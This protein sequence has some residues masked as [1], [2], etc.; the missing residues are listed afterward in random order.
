MELP[1][2]LYDEISNFCKVNSIEN[3]NDFILKLTKQGFTIE[4]YGAT[5][6]ERVVEKTV[7]IVKEVPVEK[8]VEVIKEVPIEKLTIDE[9]KVFELTTQL[10]NEIN[11]N[12]ELNNQIISLNN[13]ITK[14][15]EKKD[16]YGER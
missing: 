3:V 1:Q 7:E 2:S 10:N 8:I 4:K 5:P 16:I 15:K 14:L 12:A 13:E 6:K 9:T 11:K